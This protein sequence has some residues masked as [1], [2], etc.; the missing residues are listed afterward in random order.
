MKRRF[1]LAYVK[2]VQYFSSIGMYF[3]VALRLVVVS[4]PENNM[5]WVAKDAFNSVTIHKSYEYAMRRLK[6]WAIDNMHQHLPE[7]AI[8]EQLRQLDGRPDDPAGV[9]LE[10]YFGVCRIYRR[11]IQ[12]SGAAYCAKVVEQVAADDVLPVVG[13]PELVASFL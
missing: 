11:H 12:P 2:G 6:E 8:A 10:W 13:V 1:D 7:E 4:L 9:A 5:V 3:T